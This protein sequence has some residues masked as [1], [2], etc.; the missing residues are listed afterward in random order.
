MLSSL[1]LKKVELVT[2]LFFRVRD[3]APYLHLNWKSV[4]CFVSQI[5]FGQI[6]NLS[7]AKQFA[8]KLLLIK[9]FPKHVHINCWNIAVVQY[10]F[11]QLFFQCF[12]QRCTFVQCTGDH[13]LQRKVLC[14]KATAKRISSLWQNYLI[15]RSFKQLQKSE[16]QI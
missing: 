7:G 15:C 12:C 8:L 4:D 9:F 3:G 13:S 1:S 11:K 10:R 5:Y 16:H 6:V 2:I 14:Q